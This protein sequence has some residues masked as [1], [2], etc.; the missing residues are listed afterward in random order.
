MSVF[1]L[2][3]SQTDSRFC[4]DIENFEFSNEHESMVIEDNGIYAL[5]DLPDNFYIN[6][7]VQG[8]SQR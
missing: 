1:T 7:N 4:G 6:A 2:G 3:F 5:N 8:Y